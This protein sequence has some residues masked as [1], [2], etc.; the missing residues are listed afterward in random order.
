MGWKVEHCTRDGGSGLERAVKAPW[1][2][3]LPSLDT[4][5]AG[6]VL[7]AQQGQR[8]PWSSPRADFPL[9]GR[10]R[11]QCGSGSPCQSLTY[12]FTC[13]LQ[14]TVLASLLFVTVSPESSVA[15]SI[16]ESHVAFQANGAAARC[17]LCRFQKPRQSARWAPAHR[18]VSWGWT[19]EAG[20]LS[21]LFV[22][23][24]TPG[25]SEWTAS[26]PVPACHA[27]PTMGNPDPFFKKARFAP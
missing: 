22:R 14:E 19:G 7:G 21:V 16:A 5:S 8:R 3:P 23:C 18:S 15:V 11:A 10:S 4:R 6:C 12:V 20:V 27:A 9:G 1:G 2:R 17:S 25:A 13:R 24:K 26:F